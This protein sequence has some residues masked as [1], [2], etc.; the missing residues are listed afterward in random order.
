V[1]AK[2]LDKPKEEE[3]QKWIPKAKRALIEARKKAKK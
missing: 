3:P 2:V 1:R